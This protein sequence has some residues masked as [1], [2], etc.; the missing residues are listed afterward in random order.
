[1]CYF[2]IKIL[3]KRFLPTKKNNYNPPTCTDERLRYITAECGGL[4]YEY[5][6]QAAEAEQQRNMEMWNAIRRLLLTFKT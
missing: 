1:M 5:G 6:Q 2:P 3:N 4:Q